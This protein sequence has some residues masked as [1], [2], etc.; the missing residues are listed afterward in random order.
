MSVMFSVVI[1]VYNAEK[2]LG[3]CLTSVTE[4]TFQNFEIIV[5]DDGST[6]RSPQICDEF[7][8]LN[9]SRI[10][11]I[12]QQNRGQFSARKIG[13]ENAQGK[14]L[15][16]V[17]ADDMLDR[18]ALACLNQIY[19]EQHPDMIVF[20]L[21]SVDSKGTK[22]NSSKKLFNRGF[23]AK[24]EFL[25][26]MICTGKLNSIVIKSFIRKKYTLELNHR[27][28]SGEDYCMSLMLMDDIQTV[29]YE[30]V[31]LYR[32]RYNNVST[33]HIRDVQSYKDYLFVAEYTLQYIRTRKLGDD[34]IEEYLNH[35]TKI[36]GIS[37]SQ[38]CLGKT[39]S[40]SEILADLYANEIVQQCKQYIKCSRFRDRMPLRLFY[41]QTNDVLVKYEQ[42]Y[43]KL[44]SWLV[45]I[46]RVFMQLCYRCR[47]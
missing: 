28:S 26:Q 36:I 7:S 18:N 42:I 6:D 17:D 19:T 41:H 23:L 13:I 25:H 2:Y 32:Y 9:P 10:K 16:F 21:I 8:S 44:I 3:E 4:Q 14:Y 39:Q 5:V 34:L 11:V 45:T 37:L 33:T 24:D 40:R 38:I 12:H 1:P 47:N 22:L 30:P 15:V 29:W 20:L 43:Q 46:K 31:E 35:F 27:L